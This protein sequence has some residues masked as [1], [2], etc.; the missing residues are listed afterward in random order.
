MANGCLVPIVSQIFKKRPV[1]TTRD[2]IIP[3]NTV[4]YLLVKSQFIGPRVITPKARNR[5]AWLANGL[6][7]LPATDSASPAYLQFTNFSDEP[8]TIPKGFVV[9][10]IRPPKTVALVGADSPTP[11]TYWKEKIDVNHLD[12]EQQVKLFDVLSNFSSLWNGQLGTVEGVKHRIDTGDSH[13]V[14]SMPYRAGPAQRNLEKKEVTRML[15]L[16]MIEPSDAEWASPVVLVPKADGSTRFCIDYRHLNSLTKRDSYPLPRM[17]ELIESLGD[18]TLFSTLDANSGYW[19]IL[20]DQES[21]DRTSFTCHAVFYR[22]K[23][24]PFGLINAPATFQRALDLILSIVRYEFAL[25]YLDDI[26]IFIRTFDEH[27]VHLAHVLRLLKKANV[28]LKL[29]K[30]RFAQQQVQYLGHMIKP[31]RLEMLE[32]R[33]DALRL[34]ELPKTKKE[35]R[36]FLGLASFY[37]RFVRRFGKI[38][39]PLYDLTS[40]ETPAK[41]PP[42]F[43]S[44]RAAF[45]ELKHALTNPPT[46]GL[47]RVVGD[48]VMDTDVSKFQI[49]CG[50]HQKD[51]HGRHRP[52]GYFSRVLRDAELNYSTVEKEALAVVWAVKTLRPYLEGARFRVRSDQDSLQW[53]F[54][55]AS[56]DDN[57]CLAS[58]R[59]KLV[60]YEFTVT[61]VP[62]VMNGPADCLSRLPTE[63]LTDASVEAFDDIPCLPVEHHLPHRPGPLL[64][65]REWDPITLQEFRQAQEED[66]FCRHT[67]KV[68]GKSVVVVEE[69]SDGILV[70]ISNKDGVRQR[71]VPESLKERVL[72][73][74]HYPKCAGHPGRD[75]MFQS[76]RRDFF[77]PSMSRDVSELVRLCPSC[78]RKNLKG[79]KKTTMLKLFPPSKPLEFVAL[80]L[81]G[82]LP[83]TTKGNRFILV[84]GDRYSKVTQ[85]VPLAE[86]TADNVAHAFVKHWILPY[87]VPLLVLSDNGSQFAAKFFQAVFAALG[88]K[89]LFTSTYDPQCNGQIER[90]NRVALERF[91]HYVCRRQD[92]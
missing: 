82:P 31:G 35:L 28:S 23:R 77:W 78:A 43:P 71:I 15:E 85:A 84:I 62:G 32:A 73:L 75:K 9:G 39:K 91:L 5:K 8:T 79:Q 81:L 50:L 92:D 33:V 2:Q 64:Q 86:I 88:I 51:E 11:D 16:D 48:F 67:R 14:W 87:G 38:S 7:S 34:V 65:D 66:D 68:Q 72:C 25:V 89:Q 20:L 57:A 69:E 6:V 47:P 61:H 56:A 46:L 22:F 29:S 74:S 70:R 1:R 10:F 37:R 45:E 59:L 4:A 26:I 54:K 42:F 52:L 36:S 90:F 13:P 17:D 83:M 30:C 60:G 58:F 63:R 53:I 12:D 24:L 80:D 55:H 18:A 44:Q 19:Q 21:K 49:G 3:P 27:M 40:E 76:L 41:L